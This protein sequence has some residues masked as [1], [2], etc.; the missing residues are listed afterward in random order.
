[1]TTCSQTDRVWRRDGARVRGAVTTC[2]QSV[3]QGG[4]GKAS[5]NEVCT[6][7]ADI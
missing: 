7:G 3:V 1:M 6:V 2:S 5:V 4:V